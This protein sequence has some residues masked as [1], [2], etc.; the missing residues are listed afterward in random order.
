MA[1][2]LAAGDRA[3][4]AGRAAT[5][6]YGLLRGR[7]PAPEVMTTAHRRIR[8]VVVHRARSIDEEHIRVW[9]GIRTTTIARTVVDLAGVCSL[10]TLARIHHEADV[11]FRIDPDDVD[12]VLALRPNAPGAA[13]LRAVVHGDTPLLLSR[14][15]RGFRRV[16]RE[17]GFAMPLFNRPEGAHYVDCRWPGFTVELDSFRFHRTRRAWE[18]DHDRVRAAH[19]RGDAFRRFTWRDV[20]EDQRYMLGQLERRLPRH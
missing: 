15:E 3:A 6:N 12:A 17:H 2:V 16:L 9:N 14:L 18:R 13:L 7:P 1:A 4:L 20:F 19:C 8:G 11:R 5:H 10:D